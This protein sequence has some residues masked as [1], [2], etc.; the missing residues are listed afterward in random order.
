MGAKACRAW[1]LI[2]AV[3]VSSAAFAAGLDGLA[4]QSEHMHKMKNGKSPSEKFINSDRAF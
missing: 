4:Y 3:G 2:V 1:A